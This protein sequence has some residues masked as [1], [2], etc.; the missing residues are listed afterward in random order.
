FLA[1]RITAPPPEGDTARAVEIR[2]RVLLVAL[3]DHLDEAQVLLL[4]VVNRAGES[5]SLAPVERERAAELLQASRLYRQTAYQVGEV[6]AADVLEELERI[7]LDMSQGPES[8]EAR[9]GLRSRIEERDL[10]FKLR[11]L[12]SNVKKF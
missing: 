10:L 4:E 2:E 7:F 8:L 6:A 9:E 11:V 5:P 12:G 1:G 3:S